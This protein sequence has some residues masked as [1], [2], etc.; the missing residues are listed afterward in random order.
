MFRIVCLHTSAVEKAKI[1]EMIHIDKEFLNRVELRKQIV[2][3]YP[4]ATVQVSQACKPAVDELY[5]FLVSEH[6]PTQQANVF[7][8]C[9]AQNDERQ[10][11]RAT[12]SLLNTINGVVYPLAPQESPESTLKLLSTLVDEDF[13][14]LLPSPEGYTLQGY[15][16][17]FS[18]GFSSAESGTSILGTSLRDLHGE[19][20]GYKQHL[21]SKMERWIG[22][23]KAG[24]YWKR[25]NVSQFYPN[26]HLWMSVVYIF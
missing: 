22:N 26:D 11:K 1:S 5:S 19:V 9:N 12:K 3:R 13:M 10:Q 15:L 7:R 20:P 6:L 8:L 16:M 17:C 21:E 18:S 25:C 4:K 2:S 23:I 14:F 24:T